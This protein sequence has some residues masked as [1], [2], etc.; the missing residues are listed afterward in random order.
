MKLPALSVVINRPIE[1]V[2]AYVANPANASE[3]QMGCEC[4]VTS[5]T[6]LGVGTT[7]R[8]ATT[9]L[10]RRLEKN[11]EITVYEPPHKFVIVTTSKSGAQAKGT[12]TFEAV[13][14]GTKITMRGEAEIGAS[15]LARI[16]ARLTEP[17]FLRIAQ[18]QAEAA[19]GNLKELM[20]ARAVGIA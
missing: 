1:E 7:Y 2:F 11:G 8:S 5:R 18:R 4:E 3:W 17:L 9:F 13:E 15:R 14:G 16:S 10:G 6:P 20:E 19:L 12:F